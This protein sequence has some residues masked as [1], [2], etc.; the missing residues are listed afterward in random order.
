M[1]EIMNLSSTYNFSLNQYNFYFEINWEFNFLYLEKF[2]QC[3]QVYIDSGFYINLGN[4]L[5]LYIAGEE[6]YGNLLDFIELI[7][8]NNQNELKFESLTAKIS[9][10]N[11]ILNMKFKK[12]NILNMEI[13]GGKEININININFSHELYAE[14]NSLVSKIQDDYKKFSSNLDVIKKIWFGTDAD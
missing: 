14:L 3:G 12:N 10:K 4:G 11:N 7:S 6:D 9:K 2:N 5:S 8:D 13:L 1:K